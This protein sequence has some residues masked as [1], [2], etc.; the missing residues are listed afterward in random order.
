MSNERYPPQ[1]ND[2]PQ[3]SPE[4]QNRPETVLRDGALKATIWRNDGEKGPFFATTLAKTYEDRNGNLKD[5][6]R[7]SGSDLL[8]VS[9]LARQAYGVS[10]N[11]QREVARDQGPRHEDER[12]RSFKENRRQERSAAPSRTR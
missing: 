7:F 6:N 4:P 9:E 12:L 8:R 5:T 10:R 3:P 1:A 11:L 2:A